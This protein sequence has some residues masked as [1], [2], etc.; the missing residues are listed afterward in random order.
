M[1]MT[2]HCDVV[3]AEKELFSGRVTMVVATGTLGELG[4]LP[5]H[6]PLLTGIMPGP[7]RLLFDN[8]TEEMI[9]ASGGYLEVQPGIVTV[10]ADTAERADDIDE[11]AAIA[12]KEAAEKALA[13]Q[14]SD[15]EYSAVAAQLAEASAQLRILRK[16]R[17][18]GTG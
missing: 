1:A 11:A 3:S 17:G 15:F 5:G 8:G 14:T 2:M 9:F 4:I 10:L 12:A 18:R 6:A 16:R 7:V 13:E